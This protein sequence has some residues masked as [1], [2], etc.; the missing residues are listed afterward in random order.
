MTAPGAAQPGAR[1]PT[2]PLAPAV[3]PTVAIDTRPHP[4]GSA[5]RYGALQYGRTPLAPKLIALTIDDGPDPV[6]HA[7]VLQIL[8]RHCIKAAFFFVGRW[9]EAHPDLVRETA[10]RGHV[11]ATHSLSHPNNLRRYSQARQAQEISGGFRAAEAALAGAPPDQR[12][13]LAPFF[14]FPGLNDGRSMLQYLGKRNIAAFSSD[15]G[16][17][18]WKRISGPTIL[19]RALK[20]GEETQGGVLI[21]HETRPNAVATLSELITEFEKRGYRFVQIVPAAGGRALAEGAPDP[22]L[23]PV[24]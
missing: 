17:D 8:D 4:D 10:A 12:L 23:H 14:R 11:I 18:D 6:H 2:D 13:R 1:C 20:Y 15:F 16:D 9:A 7:E 22:L 3:A 21:F 19:R 24:R 5:A